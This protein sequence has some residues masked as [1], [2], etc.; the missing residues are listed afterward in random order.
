MPL[1]PRI[2]SICIQCFYVRLNTCVSLKRLSGVDIEMINIPEQI[3]QQR[4]YSNVKYY[5]KRTH[6]TPVSHNYY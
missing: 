4:T 5:H 2:M 3:T 6:E 1:Y